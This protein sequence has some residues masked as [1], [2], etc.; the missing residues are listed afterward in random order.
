MF[1]VQTSTTV[2][3]VTRQKEMA[4]LLAPYSPPQSETCLMPDDA[5]L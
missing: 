2:D 4:A 5:S 1:T 3:E